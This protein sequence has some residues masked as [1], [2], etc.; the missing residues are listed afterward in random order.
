MVAVTTHT[1]AHTQRVGHDRVIMHTHRLQENTHTHTH[2]HTY[3]V[4]F[5]RKELRR[6]EDLSCFLFK[7]PMP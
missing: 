6:K 7:S 5:Q 1:H 4:I 3:S 2:T